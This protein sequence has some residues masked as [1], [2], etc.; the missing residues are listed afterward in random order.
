VRHGISNEEWEDYLVGK[1]PP[2]TRARIDAHLVYCT[3]CWQLYEQECPAMSALGNAVE[4]AR[5]YLI[6]RDE[7]LRPMFARVMANVRADDLAVIEQIHSNLNF[8]QAVLEPVFGPKAAQRAMQLAA[9][10]SSAR[11]LNRITRE[12]WNG[13]LERLAAIASIICGDVFAG[14]IREYGQLASSEV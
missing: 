4:E 11:A 13:F 1:S 12:N 10:L 2:E 9:S 3:E 7:R 8:L 14:L 6:M 5:E